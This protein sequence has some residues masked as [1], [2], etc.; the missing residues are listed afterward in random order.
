VG[1]GGG[2]GGLDGVAALAKVLPAL[3]VNGDDSAR[4]D[5][6]AQLDGVGSGNGVA[7]RSGD[8]EADAAEVQQGEVDLD[9]AGDLAYAVVEHGVAGDPQRAVILAVPAQSEADDVPRPP[10][11]IPGRRA[12]RRDSRRSGSGRSSAPSYAGSPRSRGSGRWSSWCCLSGVDECEQVSAEALLQLPVEPRDRIEHGGLVSVRSRD[13]P[14]SL[15]SDKRAESV[16]N[17][18]PSAHTATPAG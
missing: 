8:R 7:Q 15:R 2:E 11:R 9:T 17:A 10:P 6:V 3:I 4:P 14:G 1:R 5:E 16:H 12:R 18:V 13:M